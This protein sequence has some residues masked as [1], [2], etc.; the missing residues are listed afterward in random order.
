MESYSP[1]AVVFGQTLA[2]T[3]FKVSSAASFYVPSCYSLCN[4]RTNV[5]HYINTIRE[6]ILQAASKNAITQW[7]VA[8]WIFLGLF[9]IV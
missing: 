3:A 9:S 7:L 4:K 2:I 5:K 1:L 8:A 6:N